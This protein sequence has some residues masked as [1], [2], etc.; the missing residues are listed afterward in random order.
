[1]PVG[2]VL[3]LE[4]VELAGQLND[5]PAAQALAGALPLEMGLSRWGEEYY[6]DL[7]PSLGPFAGKQ[8]EVLEVGELAFWPPGN[9]LC[10]FFGPTPA[11]QGDECRAASPV[12]RLGRVTGDLAAVK[13]LG[14]SVW[15][16]LSLA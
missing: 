4:G 14:P 6:G 10:L 12:H 3:K 7:G 1:M 13:A 5:S 11:S 8:V 9:A 2:V 16:V 15:A